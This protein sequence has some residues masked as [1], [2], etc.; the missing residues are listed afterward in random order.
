[1]IIF[2]YGIIRNSHEILI[3]TFSFSPNNLNEIKYYHDGIDFINSTNCFQ[4]ESQYVQCSYNRYWAT[5]DYLTIGIFDYQE[6]DEKKY[7][8]L[9]SIQDIAFTKIF[10][11]KNEI[12]AYIYFQKDT[13]YPKIQ[14]KKLDTYELKLNDVFDPIVLNSNGKYTLNNGL[15]YSDGIKINDYKIA[16][17]LTSDNLLNLL[18]CIL[19]LYNN[20][21][22]LRL[23]YFYLPLQQINIKIEVNIRALKVGNFFGLVLFNSNSNYPGYTLFNFPNFKNDNDYIN[24]TSK[25]IEIFI[26]SSS[27]AFSFEENIYLA[28]DIFGEEI[29][30]IKV[31]NFEDKSNSGV[32][33]KSLNLESEISINDEL[34]FNDTLIFEPNILGAFPGKYYIELLLILKELDYNEADSLADETK[35]YGDTTAYYQSTTFTGNIFKLIYEVKCYE[36]YKSCTQLGSESFYY[37]IECIDTFPLNFNEGEKCIC[38]YINIDENLEEYCTDECDN[39]IYIKY[40][41]KKYC[42]SSCLFDNE[43]LYSDEENKKCYISCSDNINGNIF[44]YLKTCVNQCPTNYTSNLNNI[45]I[46]DEIKENLSESSRFEYITD[47]DSIDGTEIESTIDSKNIENETQ[48]IDNFNSDKISSLNEDNSDSILYEFNS[49][50][51]SSLIKN[52]TADNSR[53]KTE[54]INNDTIITCYSSETDLNTL[55][56]LNPDLTHINLDECL[57]K[58]IKENNLNDG[59]DLLILIK[60]Y[61]NIS[62][63]KKI[64]YNIFTK[65]GKNIANST[66]CY[67]TKI[68]VSTPIKDLIEINFA[69]AVYLSKQGYD[70]YNKSSSFYY[71]YCLSA[72]VNGNDL[73]LNLRQQEI[74]PKNASLCLDGCLYNDID[75]DTKRINCICNTNIN[76][77]ESVFIEEVENNFFTYLFDMINYKITKCYKKLYNKNNY[78]YN[79]GFYIGVFINISFIILCILY[80]YLGKKSIRKQYISNEPNMN[81]IKEIELNFNL[82][83]LKMNN[84]NN[85]NKDIDLISINKNLTNI[86]NPIQK[87]KIERKNKKKK[88][89]GRNK[90]KIK[91]SSSNDNIKLNVNSG[92]VRLIKSD[93]LKNDKSNISP[94]IS[95]YKTKSIQSI[96]YDNSSKFKKIN[97]NELPYIEALTK[98]KRNVFQIFYSLFVLKLE[99]IQILVYPKEFTHFSLSLSLYFFEILLD[100]TINSLLFSDD[101]FSEKYYNNGGLLF[102]TTN[103]LSISSNIISCFILYLLEK[104]TNQ[105]EVLDSASKEIKNTANYLKIFIKLTSWFNKKIALF[106]FILFFVVLFCTYYLFIF[107]AIYKKIQKDLFINYIVGSLWSLGFTVFIC[108]CVTI[109]RK[110]SINKKIKRLFI[111][112]KYIDDKF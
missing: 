69:E 26:D 57:E 89:K 77:D 88:K 20:D 25:E 66:N 41:Y 72:Y 42:L 40:E 33:I 91:S 32:I 96:L 21:K 108:L 106:Y 28:N 61:L 47:I 7:Y 59:S 9:D 109:T 79:F 18:I 49:E 48:L 50:K 85:I 53:L 34:Q 35:Y 17:I 11:I 82:Q 76:E 27:Y 92:N 56:S 12:G 15:F 51:M 29:D 43:E 107:F 1:M 112:S 10:H 39:Y 54:Q 8:D 111:I 23:R 52:F 100:L 68:E 74:Y 84:E 3:K 102:F 58:L 65:D 86:S 70:I 90:I 2:V 55:I 62:S 31:I 99:T 83:N 38:N 24:N 110:I 104:L 64:D 80:N 98:D 45:C 37:C 94:E 46:L 13:N 16:V 60:E 95:S 105:N 71:D 19:D 87:L 67:N 30:K 5:S 78:K 63:S 14:I 73:T 101:V 4:T 75:Y 22:S 103:L 6:L 44:S 97:Y 93:E 36:K 81:E